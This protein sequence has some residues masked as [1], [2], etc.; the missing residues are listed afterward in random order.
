MNNGPLIFLGLF[1]ALASS[2]WGM[3]VVPQL[4]L[5]QQTEVKIERTGTLYP[6][7]R[8][9]QANQGAQVYRALGC[10]AC[11]TQQVRPR[12]Q[13]ADFERGWGQRRSVAQDYLRDDPV[14][15]GHLRVGPDLTNIGARQPDADLQLKHLYDP[16]L[17]TPGS[18]M[19][20]YAFLFEKRKVQPGQT[21]SPGALKLDGPSDYEVV[22]SEAARDLVAYLLSL[23]S[24]TP[25]FEAPLPLPPKTN[26]PASD[27]LSTNGPA[28][29]TNAAAPAPAL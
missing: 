24:D 6:Q 8:P 7:G 11:H 16:Q 29:M 19:P 4:T 9:G 5:G 14:L 17:V 1:F 3:V 20:P 25:L 18:M 15:L 10:V 13:G 28:A 26:A 2:F 21:Q 12:G 22:P 27:A 23:R